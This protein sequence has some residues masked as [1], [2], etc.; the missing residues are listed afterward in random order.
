M[1]HSKPSSFWL[2]SRGLAALTLVGFAVYFLLVEHGQHLWGLLPFLI[3]LLCPLMHLFMHGGHGH[4]H[5]DRESA[6]KPQEQSKESAA[7]Q[8][9]YEQAR[10]DAEQQQ[11]EEP[12]D[13]RR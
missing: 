6:A 11:H 5:A 4:H 13:E 9:G 10:K 3:L 12:S 7:Y 8:A 1:S 2:S